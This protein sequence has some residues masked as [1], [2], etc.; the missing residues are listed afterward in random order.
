MATTTARNTGN[1]PGVEVVQAYASVKD[2]PAK[3]VGFERI[4]LDPGEHRVIEV[5]FPLARLARWDVDRHDWAPVTGPVHVALARH[6]GDP[7]AAAVSVSLHP[8]I[9]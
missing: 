6:A 2:G 4:E 8:P 9:T 1:R 5:R 7:E 3:L